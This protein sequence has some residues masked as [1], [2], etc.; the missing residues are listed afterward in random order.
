MTG[1][2][3]GRAIRRGPSNKQLLFLENCAETKLW[4]NEIVSFLRF[5]GINGKRYIHL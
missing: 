4:I 2:G 3:D 1:C 5:S